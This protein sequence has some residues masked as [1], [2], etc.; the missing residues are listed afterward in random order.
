MVRLQSGQTGGNPYHGAANAYYNG[1]NYSITTLHNTLANL[2]HAPN[3]NTYELNKKISSMAQEMTVLRITVGQQTQQLANIATTPKVANPALSAPSTWAV[4]P[5]VPTNIHLNPGATN[6]YT[7]PQTANFA[8]TITTP[9]TAGIPSPSHARE[10]M[11]AVEGV[12]VED[13]KEHNLTKTNQHMDVSHQ[14]Q[15]EMQQGV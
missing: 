14:K 11:D 13:V 8:P 4:P 3:A 12:E 9:T 7:P 2:T 5:P 1:D 15:E 6:P 10:D